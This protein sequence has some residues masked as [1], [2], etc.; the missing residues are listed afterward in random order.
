[1]SGKKAAT[2]H[3]RGISGPVCEKK[4]GPKSP[5]KIAIGWGE[6]NCGACLVHKPEPIAR[7]GKRK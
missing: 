5:D 3:K 7:K 2:V 6:V 1:M 4:I